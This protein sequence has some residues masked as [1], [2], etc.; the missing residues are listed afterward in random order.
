MLRFA[1]SKQDY[2][3]I[4]FLQGSDYPIK[5]P[6][7][8]LSF[9]LENLRVEFIRGCSI[10]R[11]NNRF[12]YDKC[13][14]YMYPNKRN[15]Y[16]RFVQ[17]VTLKFDIKI[18]D[19]FIHENGNKYEVYWGSAQWAITGEC[20]RYIVQ[21]YDNHKLFNKWFLHAYTADETY[22]VTV[23]MNS[24]FR[25]KTSHCGP[26][27]EARPLNNWRNLT[28]FDYDHDKHLCKI[29]KEEDYPEIVHLNE[30]YVRKVNTV[31][32]KTLLELI[33]RNN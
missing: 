9:F 27:P 14:Y 1:L 22:F 30:L 5:S 29:M 11:S 23:I 28:Y 2:D 7:H 4:I 8:I 16:T 15:L 19:G 12:L 20:A 33:D 31:E 32:S 18:R 17:K 3:R 10:S 6:Q 26:E 13:R 21:W 24:P 25:E